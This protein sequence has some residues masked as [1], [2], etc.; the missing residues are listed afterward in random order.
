MISFLDS[1]IYALVLFAGLFLL[2]LEN[3]RRTIRVRQYPM[4]LFA[5]V[6]VVVAAIVLYKANSLIDRLLEFAFQN[7]PF[8]ANIYDTSWLY[9]IENLVVLIGFLILKLILRAIFV[10]VF[11]GDSFLGSEL[12]S[13]FYVYNPELA[14]WFVRAKFAELRRFVRAFYW[15]AVAVTIVYSVIAMEFPTWPGFTAIAFPILAMIILAEC[16][17]ATDGYTEVEYRESI[18]GEKDKADRISDYAA[19]REV[20]RETFPDRYLTDDLSLSSADSARTFDLLEDLAHSEIEADQIASDYFRR[21]KKAGLVLDSNLVRTTTSLMQGRSALIHDPFFLDLEPYLILPIHY[22]LLKYQRCLVICGRDAVATDM[23]EWITTGLEQMTGVPNLWKVGVLTEDTDDELDVGVLRAADIHSLSIMTANDDFL[24]GVGFVVLCEPS[25]ILATGQLGLGLIV[26]R[27][28]LGNTPTYACFDRNHDGLVDALSH[29]LK[30]ELVEV[31]AS[32]LPHGVSSAMVWRSDGGGMQG[33]IVPG[34][35]RYL[36]LGTELGAVALKYQVSNVTWV[37]SEVFPVNDM[38]WIAGQ[39]YSQLNSFAKLDVSQH[40]LSE[41][42]TPVVNAMGVERS[43]NAFL[44]AEDDLRNVYESLRL[45][46]DRAS[47]QNFVNLI[48]SEYLLRDYMIENR[49]IF[50]ADPKA[51]PAVVADYART[52]RNMVLRL[53]ML[54]HAFEVSEESLVKDL[55]LHGYDLPAI[56]PSDGLGVADE[57]EPPAVT[58]MRELIARHTTAENVEFEVTVHLESISL[59]GA[60]VFGRRISIVDRGLLTEVLRELRSAYYYV[61]DE[62][63]GRDYIGSALYGHVFQRMLPGQFLTHAGKYYE[64]LGVQASG[65]SAGVVLRRAADH[66]TDRMVYR[67]LRDFEF[68]EL[69]PA[70]GDGSVRDIDN[71]SIARKRTEIRVT[72][73]G[74]LEMPRRSDVGGARHVV[75]RGVPQRSYFNK[76]LL[77]IKL[78]DIPPQVRR[79][80]VLLLNE[81]FVTI[82]PHSHQYVVALTE[83]DE[84]SCGDLLDG[85]TGGDESAIYIVEDSLVDLGLLVAVERMWRRLFEIIAD[86]LAWASEPPEVSES[87]QD[88]DFV[89]VFPGED[90]AAARA[91][92]EAADEADRS[93]A[94]QRPTSWWRRFLRWLSNPFRRD[95]DNSDTDS[96]SAAP[97]PTPDDPPVDEAETPEL[98]EPDFGAAEST[99]FEPSTVTADTEVSDPEVEAS[100]S[101]EPAAGV[102]DPTESGDLEPASQPEPPQDLAE[103]NDETERSPEETTVERPEDRGE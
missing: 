99:A 16:Y 61:E 57:D 42:L 34:V 53:I 62:A 22:N 52:E 72:S 18:L 23:V 58:L 73:H 38:A 12:I 98:S 32:G 87:A 90:E 70:Y 65:D 26:S 8:L 48:S 40:A 2:R 92:A 74:Y 83:D 64:V 27:L 24:A 97:Q 45:Y 63:E 4:P 102:A 13:S 100:A 76:E 33:S 56:R 95:R 69:A 44:V 80:I 43:K 66:L 47:G 39:Y 82:F 91:R 84:R 71:V 9:R 59:D 75:V 1:I 96:S 94:P 86:Y 54:M 36:G 37:G 55:A 6:Y 3:L 41:S 28:N 46:S 15:G 5:L 30:S 50:A 10:R 60:Q 78:P 88:E 67:Q 14:L 20:L 79:T 29:L 93:G 21:R 35:S 31:V 68:G 25:R 85:F 17:Y 19:L 11:H 89:A 77:E 103:G 49:E 7:V 51:V 101:A 81:L